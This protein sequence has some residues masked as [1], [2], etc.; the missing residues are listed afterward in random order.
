MRHFKN[1][2]ILIE[3]LFQKS[4]TS[5]LTYHTYMHTQEV[6]SKALDAARALNLETA[7]LLFV[8]GLFHDTGYLIGYHKH[9][10][11][12]ME[13][14]E[15]YLKKNQIPFE[16]INFINECI[17]ATELGV[18]PLQE[19]AALLKD[20]DLSYGI[21]D[22]FFERGPQLRK[23]W[24]LNLDKFYSDDDWEKLQLDFL[25]HVLFSS[26]YAKTH[27]KPIVEENLSSQRRRIL[28]V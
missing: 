3:D 26:N 2:P 20:C 16:E 1:I 7:E 9:E 28:S 24:E 13:L 6:S 18:S 21:T 10:E 11:K 17:A 22:K 15:H 23:E 5:R 14:A 4:D 27:F 12:S 8:A 25:E 19:A